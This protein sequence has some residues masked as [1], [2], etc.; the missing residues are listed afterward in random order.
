MILA[1]I[2]GTFLDHSFVKLGLYEFPFRPYPEIFSVNILFTFIAIPILVFVYLSLMQK[3]NMAGKIG[4]VLFLSL[5]MP[6]FEK[7]SEI[8]GLFVHSVSWKHIY[9]FWGFIA[10]FFILYLFDRWVEN[11]R[12]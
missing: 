8:C 3:I 6:I 1:A 7:I 10:F 2:I 4:L 12:N 9:T 5:L 11:K